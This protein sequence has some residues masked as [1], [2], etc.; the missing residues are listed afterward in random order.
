[1][2]LFLAGDVMTGRGVDQILGHP[3]DPV[4]YERWVRS[5]VEYVHLAEQRHGPI[6]RDAAP[7][8]IWGD[9]LAALDT[10]EVDVR[11]I[12]LETAVTNL[13]QPWPRKGIQYRMHPDNIDCITTAGIDVCVLANNHVL[14]W[15]YE[16]FDQTLETVVGAGMATAGAGRDRDRAWTPAITRT[17]KAARVLTLGVG[18]V[19]SGIPPAWA[20]GHGF[21]GV[22][23]VEIGSLRDIGEVAEC[24]QRWKSETDVTV[25][26]IHW[27]PNWGYEI[28]SGYREFARALIDE[29][30]VDVIHGHSS[31]HPVGIEVHRGKPIL[32]GCGDLINDYEGI[33]G[34]EEYRPELRVL[35]VVD[36]DADGL[37]ELELVPMRAHRFSL[38]PA[39]KEE[40]LWMAE[41]LTAES[42]DL[43][44][45]V[46]VGSNGRLLLHW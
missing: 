24:L 46:A 15:S 28:P 27:G 14:D 18:T 7:S 33:G 37:C 44:T 6:P 10:R 3:G 16:G 12:N 30:G 39:S 42:T 43:G 2:R 23:M 4:I 26:S 13:G 35:Y 19:S 40:T 20:A 11:I 1:M 25:V 21:P 38:V 34:H 31:H 45:Q 9:A 41:K 29:A 5:A 32:Y 22:A 36:L 8:Y 17:T